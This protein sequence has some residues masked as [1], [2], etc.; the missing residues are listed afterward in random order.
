VED[1]Q[2]LL[3]SYMKNCQHDHMN[4][5]HGGNLADVVIV[6]ARSGYVKPSRRMRFA[7]T[8]CLSSHAGIVPEADPIYLKTILDK[9][10]TERRN[11]PMTFKPPLPARY[12]F[13]IFLKL[14]R[15]A[16]SDDAQFLTYLPQDG[17]AFFFVSF[18]ILQVTAAI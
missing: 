5:S 2:D 18:S 13:E 11:G 3:K 6:D 4:S 17:E 1:V 15:I 7:A 8:C 10:E 9:L 12:R 16:S 14:F